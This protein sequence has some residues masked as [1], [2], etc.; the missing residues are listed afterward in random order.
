MRWFKEILA[1]SVACI[2][3]R[4]EAED[5]NADR[6]CSERPGLTTTA[7]ITAAGRLQTET[8]LASWTL[9]QG[10]GERTDTFLSGDTSVRY[11]IGGKTELRFGWTPYGF[12]RDRHADGSVERA[13]RIG[14][15]TVGVKTS[16]IERKG[17]TGLAMSALATAI[18]PIGRLPI[19]AGDWGVSFQLPVTYR[20]S[21][22]ISLQATPIVAAA[23]NDDGRGRHS[24][25]GSALEVEYSLSEA[26]KADLSAQ[27]TRD[28]D[29]DPQVRGTPA[30]GSVAVS[31]QPNRNMQMDLGTNVGLNKS[32]PD[33]AVYAGVSHRF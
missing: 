32:A 15:A 23:V 7:C 9:E 3:V 12:A 28:D 29:P 1:C 14:D 13:G 18:L 2:A 21:D 33:V 8:G 27:V 5:S 31:W 25:Y 20:T 24:L 30:L 10:D 16:I 11:G 6:L 22:K 4:A 26:V 19:G 17:D